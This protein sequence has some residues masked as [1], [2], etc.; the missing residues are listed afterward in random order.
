MVV[1]EKGVKIG[2]ASTVA[3]NGFFEALKQDLI[4]DGENVLI[5]IGESMNR[6]PEL[7]SEM[8]YTTKLVDSVNDCTPPDRETYRKL[9]WNKFA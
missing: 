4:K 6:A 8:I 2:P 3:V 1:F 9:L 5:N 7:L